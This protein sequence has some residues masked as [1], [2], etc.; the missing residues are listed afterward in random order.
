MNPNEKVVYQV[1]LEASKTEIPAKFKSLQD[2]VGTKY[3]MLG[4]S[5]AT[6]R[7]LSKQGFGFNTLPLDIRLQIWDEI[8]QTSNS[9]EV[10]SQAELFIEYHIKKIKPEMLWPILQ[11]WVKRIDNW[12]HSDGL[13]GYYAKM[14]LA[15]PYEVYGQLMS[16]SDSENLWERRQSV[17]VIACI[18]RN[19]KALLSF[20]ESIDSI[21]KLMMDKEYFV[22]KGIGW[23][24][25]EICRHY[26]EEQM[27]FLYKNANLM[28]STAFAT[29]TEKIDAIEKEN[30]KQL[31][32][33]AR[34]KS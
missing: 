9:Y 18:M 15:F 11:T 20:E 21:E 16:W 23:A 34:S 13:S 25:R 29:A 8:W 7:H 19:K 24:L 26:P 12:A 17:V 4:I 2:Y 6:M 33:Q 22:Q 31:R 1:L 10:L 14:F 30:L 3:N 28:S 27:Q 32:K 5:S